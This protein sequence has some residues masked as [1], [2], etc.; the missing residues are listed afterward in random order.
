MKPTLRAAPRKMW[1]AKPLQHPALQKPAAVLLVAVKIINKAQGERQITC[2]ALCV[3]YLI[4]N[5]LFK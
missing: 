3:F 2:L 1:Q 5:Q 4:N